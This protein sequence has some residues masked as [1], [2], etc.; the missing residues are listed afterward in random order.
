MILILQQKNT[1]IQNFLGKQEYKKNQ[2]YIESP[3]LVKVYD[4]NDLIIENILTG[5]IIVQSLPIDII[6]KQFLVEHWFEI[7]KNFN[8]YNIYKNIQNNLSKAENNINNY[9][10][11]NDFNRVILFSTF[12]CNADCE[13]CYE[14]NYRNIHVNMDRNVIDNLIKLLQKQNKNFIGISWF[15]GEP[16]FNK[17]IIEYTYLKLKENNI[18]FKTS[19]ITNGLLFNNKIIK[20]AKE[21]WNTRS[22]QITIDG[23]YEDYERIK[24]VPS[25]SFEK[26]LNNIQLLLENDISVSIRL[27]LGLNNYYSLKQV[28]KVLYDHFASYYSKKFSI[29]IHEI[30]GTEKNKE[31]YINLFKLNLYMES[32]FDTYQFKKYQWRNHGCMADGNSTLVIL[33]DGKISLCEHNAIIDQFSDL[34]Q[35]FYD[36]NIINKYAS[37]K[38]DKECQLCP[39]RPGCIHNV[40]CPSE[41]IKSCSQYKINYILKIKRK[42]LCQLARKKRKRRQKLMITK[43]LY[44]NLDIYNKAAAM[45]EAFNAKDGSELNY[46][47]KV[48]FYLQK[49]MNAFLNLAKEIEQKR[50]EI[51]QKYGNPSE[52]NPDEYKIP[53]DKIEEASKEIQDF[54]ELEQEVPVSMLKLDWFDNIDMNA[55]QVA[56]ISFMIEEEE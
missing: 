24:K 4:C 55:A 18:D 20:Q 17:E 50:I 3:Y 13:Y 5:E 25:G 6:D 15:G 36:I 14:K 10:L 29:N 46:P 52:E 11:L 28:I 39:M 32:L 42:Q 56:A 47:V 51:I 9:N 53:D 49:N 44:T 22:L 48:N 1:K 19:F 33:P 21:E 35:S 26:L 7:P 16:L 30:F 31:I 37:Y 54:L 45:V 40:N 27:N 8:I 43:N 2:E 38:D 12:G 23:A 41:G 34:E